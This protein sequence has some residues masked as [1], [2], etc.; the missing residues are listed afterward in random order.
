MEEFSKRTFRKLDVS[1][2]KNYLDEKEL[3]SLNLIVSMYLDYAELQ[4]KNRVIL[5][6]KDWIK[7]LDAFLQFNGQEILDNPGKVGAEIAKSFA[8][9]EFDKYSVIQDRSHESDF[10]KEIKK[11]AHKGA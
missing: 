10:D 4:A 8:E 9:A 11:I 3:N 1:I 7:K 6:M 5:Y 2:A